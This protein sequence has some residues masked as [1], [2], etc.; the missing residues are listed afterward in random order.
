MASSHIKSLLFRI[1]CKGVSGMGLRHWRGNKSRQYRMITRV[2]IDWGPI[3]C[4]KDLWHV[5]LNTWL[6]FSRANIGTCGLTTGQRI[7]SEISCH[8]CSNSVL[9]PTV[10]EVFYFLQRSIR[11]S[12]NGGPWWVAF[13]LIKVVQCWSILSSCMLKKILLSKSLL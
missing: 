10:G 2:I 5:I 13:F 1:P 11:E 8:T 12:S 4:I 7:F 3:C 6:L 9:S